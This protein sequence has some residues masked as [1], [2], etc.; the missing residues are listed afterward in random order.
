MTHNTLF[1]FHC[2]V[3]PISTTATTGTLPLLQ[4]VLGAIFQADKVD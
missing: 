4:A 2:L 3:F 1:V